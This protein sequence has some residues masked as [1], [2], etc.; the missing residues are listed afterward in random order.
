MYRVERKYLCSDYEITV[1]KQRLSAALLQD[2]HQK[3]ECYS[4]RSVYLDD[5]QD[6]CFYDNE[7]GADQRKK[8][9]IRIYPE[10]D[11]AIHFEVKEKRNGRTRKEM[12]SMCREE[13]EAIL[14]GEDTC[15][16]GMIFQGK[17]DG[18]KKQVMMEAQK[19]L[20][21]PVVIVD[22]ERSA[23][24]YPLGNVRITFDRNIAASTYVEEFFEK[25]VPLVP[26][27]SEHIHLM[28]VKYDEFLPD[29]IARILDLGNLKRVTFSKY[30]LCRQAVELKKR[31]I[32]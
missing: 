4:V 29:F 19:R 15:Y 17:E 1:L 20:L 14:R 6:S 23:F 32:Y 2:M 12:F 27:M 21:R 16:T 10:S 13:C 28:E 31:L 3:K 24:V 11:D 9:R 30:Y 25:D 7:A 18:L 22:Y 5:Y 8:Y 26:V